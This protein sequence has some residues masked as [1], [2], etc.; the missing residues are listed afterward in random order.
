[1]GSSPGEYPGRLYFE[2]LLGI[3][4]FSENILYRFAEDLSFIKYVFLLVILMNYAD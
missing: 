1:M 3:L 2:H 4:D